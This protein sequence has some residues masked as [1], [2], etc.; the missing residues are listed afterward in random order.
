MNNEI[1]YVKPSRTRKMKENMR[2]ENV[3]GT[4]IKAVGKKRDK[5]QYIDESVSDYGDYIDED[6]L[7]RG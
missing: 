6:Y 2:N 4:R 3:G 5:Q 7:V 1:E